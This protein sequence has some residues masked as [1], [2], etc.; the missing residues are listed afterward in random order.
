MVSTASRAPRA[1]RRACARRPRTATCST[2]TPTSPRSSTCACASSRARWRPSWSSRSRSASTPRPSGWSRAWAAWGCCCSTASSPWRSRSATGRPPSSW[3]PATCCRP[4]RRRRRRP[5]RAPRRAGTSC[6]PARVA[7]LDAGVRRARAARGRRSPSPCCAARASAPS[8]LDVQRAIAC[9]PRLEVRLALMLW[10]L[11]ARWGKVELGGI[12]L[13]LPLTHRLL[14]QL[15]GA[16]RPSV[17]HALARLAEAELVTG[18][19]DEWHLHGTLEQHL[20]S[21]RRARAPRRTRRPRA[22]VARRPARADAADG[23]HPG[24]AAQR[25]ASWCT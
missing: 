12:R 11:A 21:L 22:A 8:D 16:E 13:S 19:G 10:H 24:P 25:A 9:Q 18:R 3:A 4:R 2:P 7:V 6:V 17:S 20:A 23:V 15:V 5:A 14:G 1:A